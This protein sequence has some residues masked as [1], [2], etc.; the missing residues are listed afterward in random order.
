[1]NANTRGKAGVISTPDA[2]VTVVV[3][4]TDEELMIARDTESIVG[5]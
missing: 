2:K 5:K 4:P 1:V 3:S